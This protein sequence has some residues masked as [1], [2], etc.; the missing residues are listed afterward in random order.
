M[1][2]KLE[3]L[4]LH[5]LEEICVEEQRSLRGGN[6]EDGVPPGMIGDVEVIGKLPDNLK[7]KYYLYGGG[8]GG[9]IYDGANGFSSGG[10]IESILVGSDLGLNQIWDRFR[11]WSGSDVPSNPE[12]P[13]AGGS[14]SDVFNN[15][16]N[17]SAEGIE[18]MKSWEKGPS[19]SAALKPYDDNGDLPGGNMTIGWGHVILDGED[20]SA[21]ITVAQADSIFLTDLRKSINDVNN[22]VHVSLT[23]EQFD[24]LVSYSF[25][26][27][28]LDFSPECLRKLNNG[29]YAGAA[30]EMDIVTSNN[31]QLPGLVT[32]RD[33]EQNIFNDGIYYNHN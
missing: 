23:Q 25:N 14:A 1:M 10:G 13:G 32:R 12:P 6:V 17:I 9:S 30:L 31:V 19:G 11:G 27:G 8:D 7:D 29:D 26:I 4:K 22:S 15:R 16:C 18:F 28:G 24:A 20:F 3:R 2:K 21:G 33:N 5:N